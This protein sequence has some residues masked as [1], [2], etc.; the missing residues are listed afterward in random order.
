[1]LDSQ[2]PNLDIDVQRV[3]DELRQLAADHAEHA[4]SQPS[5]ARSTEE[6]LPHTP[7]SLPQTANT[8]W[9]RWTITASVV[10]LI[11]FLAGGFSLLR[12]AANLTPTPQ[13]S[14]PATGATVDANP[15]SLPDSGS[16]KALRSYFAP[17]ADASQSVNPEL[18]WYAVL[19]TAL[20]VTAGLYG[21]HIW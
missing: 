1:S 17:V 9:S 10:V 14:R 3:L 12:P 2:D 19:P 7:G 20:L 16:S 15:T 13:S 11:A 21:L 8:T 6:I 18:W 5:A 4:D